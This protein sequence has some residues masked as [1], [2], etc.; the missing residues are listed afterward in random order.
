MMRRGEGAR[1]HKPNPIEQG[2]ETV[3]AVSDRKWR[4][5]SPKR[6]SLPLGQ[7]VGKVEQPALTGR[8]DP[9]QH[10]HTHTHLERRVLSMP[11]N[12]NSRQT[13]EDKKG[14][15]ETGGGS[16][17]CKCRETLCS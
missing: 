16:N 10:S 17:Q 9:N 14:E 13:I 8:H 11:S 7:R 15:N 1:A 4:V 3:S 12:W 5:S 2:N 6:I